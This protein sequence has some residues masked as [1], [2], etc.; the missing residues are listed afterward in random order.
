MARLTVEREILKRASGEMDD[1]TVAKL[2][3]MLTDK[4]VE[5][6][7]EVASPEQAAAFEKDLRER[8][9]GTSWSMSD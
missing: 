6:V 8:V 9:A 5:T 2:V 4:T 7:H 3:A 1:T